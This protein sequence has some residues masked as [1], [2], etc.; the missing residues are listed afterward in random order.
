LNDDHYL[1]LDICAG[2]R[3]EISNN[4]PKSFKKLVERCWNAEPDLRPDISEV[5]DTLLKWWSSVYHNKCLTPTC[6]EFLAANNRK[7]YKFMESFLHE[8]NMHRRIDF[9]SR[10]IR[11]LGISFGKGLLYDIIYYFYYY[12][13][14]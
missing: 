7:N 9:C 1:A 8:L 14:Y 6:L 12:N 13:R 5:Y 4:I 10:I 3:P 2:R 11:I